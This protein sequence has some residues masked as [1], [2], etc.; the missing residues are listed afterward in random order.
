MHNES[1]KYRISIT[2]YVVLDDQRDTRSIFY[3]F[4]H[5]AQN[6]SKRNEPGHKLFVLLFRFSFSYE[7]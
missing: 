3:R 2:D 6:L 1:L 4:L 5:Q 7:H